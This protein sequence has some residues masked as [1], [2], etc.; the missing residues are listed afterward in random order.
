MG[1]RRHGHAES[2]TTRF[3]L[4]DRTLLIDLGRSRRI[5][6]SAPRGGGLVRAR[7]IINHQV[8]DNPI[9]GASPAPR[10]A[11]LAAVRRW[12]DPARYL[13]CVAA[14][15][16][17]HPPVVG[18]MT[19]VSLDRLMICR[20]QQEEFWVEGFF[21]VGVSNAVRVGEAADLGERRVVS[22]GAGTI[23]IILITNAALTVSAMVTA[24]QV[25]TEGKTAALLEA[26]VPSWTGRP[27]ATGTGTDA[28]VIVGGDGPPARYSG[29]HTTIGWLIGR[30]VRRAVAKGLRH[31]RA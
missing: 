4:K 8:P 21:T 31:A 26:E 19:A 17:A 24:V 14:R 15:L 27:G 9:R 16:Q 10:I 28:V 12:G 22:R 20:E 30:L 25:A 18:L 1:K 11:D 2:I 7:S 13:G 29:T 23:N 6:S 5:L 3:M